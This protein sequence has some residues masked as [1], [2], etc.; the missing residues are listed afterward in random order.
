MHVLEIYQS[1]QGEGLWTGTHSVFVRTVGCL[2]RC[3]YCDT[4]YAR[5]G[6]DGADL[7]PDEIVGR[8]FLLDLSHVVITGGEPMLSPDIG[9]LTRLLKDYDY[10]ITIE[11]SGVVDGEVLCD[12]MSISPKLSNSTPRDGSSEQRELHERNRWRPDVVGQLIARHPYQLKFVVDTVDDLGEVEE[13]LKQ[14]PDV[15][16]HRV[17]LMPQVVDSE[18]MLQKAEWL[19]PFCD[20]RGFRYCPRMQL[21]WYGNKR[22]T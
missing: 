21:I 18:T 13:Y 22:R 2:L 15:I 6:E 4:P 3:R 1:R 20:E 12:L 14:F 8:V 11:T 7:S 16:P 9:E 10:K 17:Y 5:D 19:L